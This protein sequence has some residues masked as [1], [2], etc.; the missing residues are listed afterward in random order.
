MILGT[1]MVRVRARTSWVRSGGVCFFLFSNFNY[2]R[3]VF[4]FSSLASFRTVTKSE[5]A[6]FIL[7]IYRRMCTAPHTAF[8]SPV[9][10]S[11]VSLRFSGRENEKASRN[12]NLGQEGNFKIFKDSVG[13]GI[14]KLHN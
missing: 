7:F 13:A 6:A 5:G 1:L 11:S 4:C 12:I 9:K 10:D 2:L 14:L 8:T 3:S